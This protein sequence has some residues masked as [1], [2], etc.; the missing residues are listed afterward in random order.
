MTQAQTT[1]PYRELARQL[2]AICIISSPEQPADPDAVDRMLNS[3]GDFG[4][5]VIRFGNFL[6]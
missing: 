1:C 5:T 2:P 4:H 3:D 6:C